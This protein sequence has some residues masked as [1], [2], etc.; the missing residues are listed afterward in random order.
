M[1]NV[2]DVMMGADVRYAS[3][4]EA[5][6]GTEAFS[7]AERYIKMMKDGKNANGGKAH[8]AEKSWSIKHRLVADDALT[9][10]N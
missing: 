5:L 10:R 6:W 3:F 7:A 4:D 8:C 1:R 9:P 2:Y